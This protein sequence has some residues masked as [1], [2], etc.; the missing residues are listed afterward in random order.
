[1]LSIIVPAYNEAN[2]IGATLT[3]LRRAAEACDVVYELIVV[4]D[5]STDD[6]AAIAQ[7]H[8]ARVV[9]VHLRHIAATRNAGA[10]AA[11]YDWLVFV[12]AD[13]HVPEQT[14]FA[15]VRALRDGA[16]G[17]G[18]AVRFDGEAPLSARMGLWIW[19]RVARVC[20]WAAG[21]F[22]FAQRAAF[23][24]VGGFDEAYYVAE[25]LRLSQALKRRGRFVILREMVATSPRKFHMYSATSY[26]RIMLLTLLTAGAVLRRRE[27]LPQWYADAAERGRSACK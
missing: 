16:V 11:R 8:G 7:R 23:T 12:D 17:G 2:G 20:R 4:D 27:H 25:E 26:F 1:M 18:A 6:T 3:A 10:V 5:G 9:T 14:L 15:T 24:Q 22:V 21:C 13:T 19:N